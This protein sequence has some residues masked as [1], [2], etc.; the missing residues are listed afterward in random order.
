MLLAVLCLLQAPQDPAWVR[1]ERALPELEAQAA[2]DTGWHPGPMPRLL[3]EGDS[4]AA[5][6]SIRNRLLQLGD[7]VDSTSDPSLFDA[8][9]HAAVLRFQ[10]RHGLA[11]DGIVGPA[12]QAALAVPLSDRVR[13]VEHALEQWRQFTAPSEGPLVEVDV[14]TAMVR[15]VDAATRTVRFEARVIVG[16]PR[17][18]TPA[19][20]STIDRVVFNPPWNV[21]DGIARNELGPQ[22]RAD[23]AALT[24]GG[25]QL[26]RGRAVVP[27]SEENLAAIGRGVSVRQR[28]GPA[29]ALG[30]VKLEVAGTSAIHL[31]DTPSRH[32]FARDNRQL[33]HGCI[34][35]E[36]TAELASLLLG[37]QW[38]AERI[39]EVIRSGATV[40]VPLASPVPVW[41]RRMEAGVDP[42]GRLWFR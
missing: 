26:L 15:L 33:S 35:V 19:M 22:F 23:T 5:V 20:T 16:A 34:R 29:N 1:L 11:S 31:H 39:A 4:S 30:R 14:R 37:E 25:Y 13:Q 38:P 32:L 18:P 6:T 42:D 40:T 36:H 41:L 7:F 3:R 21:P 9:L 28:P 2:A 10:S 12:T 8:Q 27:P 17:T 24:R